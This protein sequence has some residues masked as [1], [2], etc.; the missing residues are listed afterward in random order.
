MARTTYTVDTPAKS[1]TGGNV[2][3][4]TGDNV[5]GHYIQNSGATRLLVVNTAAAVA[6]VYVW[7]GGHPG[8]HAG[9]VA[10]GATQVAGTVGGLQT[11]VQDNQ[12]AATGTAGD[13]KILGPFP[14]SVYGTELYFDPTAATVFFYAFED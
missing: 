7:P 8:G 13:A 14:Q 4:R 5:N 10:T 2:V 6:H 11:V 12:L 3:K 1:T 9:A